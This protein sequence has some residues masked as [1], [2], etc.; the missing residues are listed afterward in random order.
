VK[1][2][3][4]TPALEKKQKVRIITIKTKKKST[5]ILITIEEVKSE[6]D[7]DLIYKPENN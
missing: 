7:S 4:T 6:E 2:P 1:R 3:D 5:F